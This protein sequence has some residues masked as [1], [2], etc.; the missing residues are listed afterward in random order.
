MERNMSD[1][2][3]SSPCENEQSRDDEH[4]KLK[5]IWKENCERRKAG[6]GPTSRDL[7]R[8]RLCMD[9]RAFDNLWTDT[10]VD[11]HGN[12]VTLHGERARAAG[13]AL[14]QHFA[15]LRDKVE[16]WNKTVVDDEGRTVRAKEISGED[17]MEVLEI[18]RGA[19]RDSE[20]TG[21]APA[22]PRS[23]PEAETRETRSH[24]PINRRHE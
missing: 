5:A 24:R 16:N 23:A 22:P 17:V 7:E 12:E 21:G 13:A 2:R 6:R 15:K 3:R 1:R 18:G 14:D 20:G 4:Q 9:P 11:A 8:L 10:F 19:S